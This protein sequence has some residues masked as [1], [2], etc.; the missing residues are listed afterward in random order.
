MTTEPV[1]LQWPA[2]AALALLLVAAVTTTATAG[3]RDLFDHLIDANKAQIVMLAE[4]GLVDEAMAKRIASALADHADT[5]S[6]AGAERNADYL[7]LEAALSETLGAEASNLHL[8]RS[9]NDL[10]AAMNRMALRDGLLRVMTSLNDARAVVQQLAGEHVDTVAP[11]FTHAVQAQPTTLA[12]FLLAFDS[13]LERDATRLRETYA[14]TNTSPLGAAAITTSGFALNRER[15]AELLG[16]E[17]LVENSYDAIVVSTADSKVEIS[18]ALSISAL[19]IGRLAQDFLFQYDDPAPAIVVSETLAGRS[20]IM[21]QKRNPSMIEMMRVLAS[22]VVGDAHKATIYAHNT[23]LHEVRD[24]RK[25]LFNVVQDT[26]DDA[27]TMYRHLATVL[28]SLDF[29]VETLRE[30]VDKDYSTMT[31]VADALYR[32]AGIPFRNGY[33]FASALSSYGRERGKRPGEI[34][35]REARNVYASVLDGEV[36][37]LDRTQFT[38]A[39]DAG[40]IVKNRKGLGGPQPD[41]VRR[42]LAEARADHT[43]NHEWIAAKRSLLQM[44]RAELDHRFRDLSGEQPDTKPNIVL[45]LVDDMGWSDMG[46]F[47]GEIETPQL[48]ELAENGLRFTQFHTTSKCFPSRGAL[49]TGLY[50]EQVGMDESPF[51]R[52]ERG[53][54][55][56]EALGPAGYRTYMVGKHH[57]LDNPVDRGFDRYVGLRDGASNHFNPGLVARPG[58][59]LPARKKGR[60]KDGRWFCFDRDCVQGYTPESPDYYSTDFYTDRAIEFIDDALMTEQPFFL[61]IAYQAPHDPLHAW[62]EDIAKYTDRYHNGFEPV[63]EARYRRMRQ[64]GLIDE[65][66]PRSA[67]DFADWASMSDEQRAD[68]TRRMAV[69][70]AMSDRIDQNLRRLVDRLK[71]ADAFDNTLILFTSDNGASA[72]LVF[73][74]NSDEE[75]GAE[76]PVGTVGRWASLGG[77]W[78]NV[79]NTPFRFYKNYP[80][81]GG[82]VSPLIVH[83]PDAIVDPGRIVHANTHLIDILPTLL[84]VAGAAYPATEPD[85]DPAPPPEGMDLS[86]YLRSSEPVDRGVPVFQRW[87]RGRSVRTERWKLLSYAERGQPA[88]AGEWELYDMSKDRTET[89]NV[90][91]RHPEVVA[92]LAEAYETWMARVKPAP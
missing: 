65:S 55:I 37:P 52:I 19:G 14:R 2:R 56:A 35:W 83:W 72:E 75:I 81:G 86:P 44:R 30:R 62:P 63:A 48:D 11:G 34:T 50:A 32:E 79:S 47:G 26:L 91:G 20:S 89:T 29:R 85:G 87:Q 76:H 10:G 59:S 24:T 4:E 8:G 12:H 33:A 53:V 73:E 66:F 68:A 31:E 82:S 6:A 51:S 16:F 57:A 23:P 58:E 77:D 3:E 40:E 7:A 54:T 9:R 88:E 84:A 78:A 18:S 60:A 39:L 25:Y 21:P 69:Y 90:A 80:H 15:L 70:A 49:L 27:D 43:T 36:L 67:P 45:V 38:A 46:A 41:E 74:I 13:A 71:Q 92:R 22:E 1:L 17:G 64:S 42:M 5:Q 61:Y 28:E